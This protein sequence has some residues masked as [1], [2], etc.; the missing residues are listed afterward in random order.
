LSYVLRIWLNLITLLNIICST[1]LTINWL[2]IFFKVCFIR[3][4]KIL[5]FIIRFKIILIFWFLISYFTSKI[6]FSTWG[7]SLLIIKV[8][9]LI[10][11]LFH[12][13]IKI[14]ILLRRMKLL[15]RNSKFSLIISKYRFS[16]WFHHRL[17]WLAISDWLLIFLIENWCFII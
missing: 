4:N 10:L 3:I 6:D 2:E 5:I 1:L 17:T 16:R 12:C 11:K 8:W 13:I 14:N 7:F 9:F 15:L